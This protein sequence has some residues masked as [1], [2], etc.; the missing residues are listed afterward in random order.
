MVSLPVGSLMTGLNPSAIIHHLGRLIPSGWVPDTSALKT[1]SQKSQQTKKSKSKPVVPLPVVKPPKFNVLKPLTDTHVPI[2]LYSLAE[3][4][5][6]VRAQMIQYLGTTRMCDT[7]EQFNVDQ[8]VLLDQEE[9]Q[10]IDIV[11]EEAPRIDSEVEGHPTAIILDGGSTSNIISESLRFL[12]VQ[13]YI[14]VKEKFPFANSKTEEFLGFVK[15]LTVEICGVR[16]LVF[17][18]I[19]QLTWYNLLIGCHALSEF[20]ISVSF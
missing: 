16:K 6:S 1:S 8:T 18:A 2:S 3:I 19:F 4:A 14:C 11:S 17:A 20:R 12:G 13:E 15:D 9:N 5:L 10:A 7:P